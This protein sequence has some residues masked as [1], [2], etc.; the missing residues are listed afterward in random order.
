[1]VLKDDSISACQRVRLNSRVFRVPNGTKTLPPKPDG[2]NGPTLVSILEADLIYSV[3]NPDN[4]YTYTWTVPE[5]AVITA[6][7]YTRSITV[8]WGSI[9]GNVTV[10]AV[11]ECGESSPVSQKV[12]ISL[13]LTEVLTIQ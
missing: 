4:S 6:G 8:L 3:K 7:Q 2:I 11:N 13:G 9:T 5:G 1:M 10:K 12:N